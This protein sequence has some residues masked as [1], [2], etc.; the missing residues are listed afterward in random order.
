[1]ASGLTGAVRGRGGG[2]AFLVLLTGAMACHVEV[3]TAPPDPI[4]EVGVGGTGGGGEGAGGTIE[5]VVTA[6]CHFFPPRTCKEPL[7]AA[8]VCGM[9]QLPVGRA[10]D[11][12]D[13]TTGWDVC[14]ATGK[15]IGLPLLVEG[16]HGGTGG[17]GGDGP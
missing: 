16:G 9:V 2:L 4:T 7:C 1:M 14:T 3:A 5:C 6:D 13:D 17:E 10:C 8:G 12:G 11:D 15:C